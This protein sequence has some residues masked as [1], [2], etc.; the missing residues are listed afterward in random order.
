MSWRKPWTQNAN[1]LVCQS[2]P[3]LF[4]KYLSVSHVAGQILYHWNMVFR[5]VFCWDPGRSSTED[6]PYRM[7]ARNSGECCRM[8]RDLGQVWR[9]R[10][11]WLFYFAAANA[12]PFWTSL[13]VCYSKITDFSFFMNWCYY[14]EAAFSL[15]IWFNLLDRKWHLL[16]SAYFIYIQ[17]KHSFPL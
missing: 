2:N 17:D 6:V 9:W 1:R 13:S 5:F 14:F 16:W 8:G 4:L 3:F 12:I 15:W 7:A 10:W 11:N